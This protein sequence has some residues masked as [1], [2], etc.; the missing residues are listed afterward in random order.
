M[1]QSYGTRL[2]HPNAFAIRAAMGLQLIHPIQPLLILFFIAFFTAY[3]ACYAA[4][5][6]NLS[7]AE[8]I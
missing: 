6:I 2:V 1:S 3:Y 4:H 5:I 7:P 8:K